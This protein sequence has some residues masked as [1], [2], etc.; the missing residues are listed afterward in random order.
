MKAVECLQRSPSRKKSLIA[1]KLSDARG[2]R[3]QGHNLA[4][5]ISEGAGPSTSSQ[6]PEPSG[7]PAI[8][9]P[10]LPDNS[11][12]S[13]A[14]L[15][16][17]IENE[18]DHMSEL[19]TEEDFDDEQARAIFYD[20]MVALLLYSCRMFA[21]VLMASFRKRQKGHSTAGGPSL[22]PCLP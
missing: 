8:H 1:A 14:P 11:T 19:K 5:A 4:F 7:V 20:F 17:V 6:E 22:T 9:A 18:Y 3:T 13:S 21:V 16:S 10:V 12:V 2:K 15:D